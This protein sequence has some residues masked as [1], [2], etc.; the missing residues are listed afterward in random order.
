MTKRIS[1]LAPNLSQN[2]LGRAYL[3]ARVLQRNYEVE[4]LGPVFQ[5][6]IWPPVDD[7]LV[8]YITVPGQ[9]F[10]MFL[11]AIQQLNR[12]I[13]GDV[14]YAVKP[15][16]TSFGIGLY[17]KRKYH[18]P[19][20]LDIDDWDDQGEYDVSRWK[21]WLRSIVRLPNPYSHAYLRLMARYI[22]DA[23]AIT[24][25]SSHLQA[26]FGG[27]L[28]THGR[29]TDALNPELFDRHS[30]RQTHGLENKFVLMFLGTPRK[31][32][33]VEDVL[34]AMAGIEDPRLCFMV[35]G[36]DEN[37]PYTAVLQ[38]YNE[39]RLKLIGM[40]PWSSIPTFLAM[41]DAIILAQQ[42]LPFAQAQIPAKVFDGMSMAKPTIATAVG[43]LPQILDGSGLIIPPQ[44]I[45]ALQNAIVT[46]MNDPGLC[47]ALG[48]HAREVC[49]THYSWDVMS[50]TLTQLIEEI[51]SS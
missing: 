36:V 48:Q 8:P 29:D 32:K 43:D 41:A 26:R 44:D 5:D 31:H 40:Q 33:G 45:S 10:P 28:V 18:K 35:V 24:V 11:G 49:Q 39:P 4:I 23:D 3:L 47:Q 42:A 37:D 17:H 14:V 7:G 15:R 50:Q 22:P 25:V 20:L 38:N 30:L 51:S 46:L 12:Q 21:R 13:S 9:N 34:L 27:V 6:R 16:L 1:I 2:N 19:L